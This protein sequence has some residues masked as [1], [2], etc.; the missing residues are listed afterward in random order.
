[1]FEEVQRA[2][3]QIFIDVGDKTHNRDDSAKET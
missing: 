2:R 1:M 3:G